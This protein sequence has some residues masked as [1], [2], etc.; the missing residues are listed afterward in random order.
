MVMNVSVVKKHN[1]RDT[2]I[3]RIKQLRETSV[4]V[5]IPQDNSSREGTE[6]N[7]A[8]LLY[9]HT[10]GVRNGKMITEMSSTMNAGAK[11]SDAYN[12]YVMS[13]GSALMNTP[14]RPVLE[15]AIEANIEPIN[16]MMRSAAKQL[17]KTGSTVGYRRTGIFAA[18]KCK[19]W[20]EDAR[21]NWA[22][23]SIY[24]IKKKGSYKPLIDSSSMRNAI[25]Y[26]V[27]HEA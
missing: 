18:A 23:N 3:K 12:L 2:I 4:L 6:I 22:P 9:I 27:D 13:H 21:N 8:E 17:M 10:H 20:F 16:D 26:V 7:N 14:P 25:T 1:N 5:G 11:Y 19:G 15:P 24:T